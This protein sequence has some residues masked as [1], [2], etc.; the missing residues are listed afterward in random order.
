MQNVG[1]AVAAHWD[2]RAESF[3][4]E[5]DHGLAEPRTRAAWADRLVA[6]LPSPPALVVDLGCGTGSLAVLLALM[7]F[8][9]TASD[10]S[11]EMVA[12]ARQ[13]AAAAGVN[14]AVTVADASHPGLAKRS[15]DVVLVRHLAW[16]LPDPQ[17]AIDTWASLL[18][19]GGRLVM[20]EG[21]WGTA[22]Q[23]A[24]EQIDHGDYTPIRGALPW[25]GG[26]SAST[27]VPVLEQAFGRVEWHDLTDE[28]ELWG[29]PVSDERY[30][31]VAYLDCRPHASLR[32]I[33]RRFPA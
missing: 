17:E 3:D 10:I 11:P 13:K 33:P 19:D 24:E 21:R 9:V 22:A 4:D 15:A 5:A 27:L 28:D 12:C 25:Y 16:T 2:R 31:V 32:G 7:G 20:V 18:R 8:E 14:V 1:A 23:G 29:Q 26:V 6:W 30:A